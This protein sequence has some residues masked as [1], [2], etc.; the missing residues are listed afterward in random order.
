MAVSAPD[1][2]LRFALRLWRTLADPASPEAN[3]VWSPY[4]V[5]SA[6]ALLAAGARGRTRT[7]LTDLLGAGP[8]VL[9]TDLAQAGRA[10]GP[11]PEIAS[12]TSLWVRSD[13]PLERDFT[14][15]L[16]EQADSSVHSAD[17]ARDPEGA[18]EAVN[19]DVAA[20]TR[21]LI[22]ELL[23]PGTIT[24]GTRALLVNAL[25]VQLV[26]TVPFALERTRPRP[27]HGPNGRRR[28]PMMHRQDSLPYAETEGWRM[29]T[30]AGGHGLRLDV[31]LPPERSGGVLPGDELLARL[32]DTAAERPDVELALPRFELDTRSDLSSPLAS[33][34]AATLFTEEADLSGIS[35]HPLSVDRVVH[36][37]RLRVDERGAEGAAATAVMM[38]RAAVPRRPARLIADRPFHVV[39]RRGPVILFLG[40]VLEPADPGPPD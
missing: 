10:R 25:W 35:P 21:G 16:R 20:T 8:E 15:L 2:H 26:W 24:A 12:A 6:L 3:I 28:V 18:R 11:A 37:A 39:V 30:L 33:C 19:T 38:V 23:A 7:E 17:F 9:R 22:T 5:A 34:G 27:F 29:V 1:P 4:S 13:L 36:R 32:R 14:E 31:V 40:T